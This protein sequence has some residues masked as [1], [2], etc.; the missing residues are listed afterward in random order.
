M[1]VGKHVGHQTRNAVDHH[2]GLAHPREV[3]RRTGYYRNYHA[4]QSN[5]TVYGGF[6]LG[7]G[8]S[9]VSS[10]SPLFDSNKASTGL[11][12]GLAI[13]APVSYRAPLFLES[14]PYYTEK[15]G[16]STYNNEKF[17]YSLNYLEVPLVLK[18]KYRADRDITIEPFV[19]GYLACGVGGKIKDYNHRAAYNS[20]DDDYDDTFN[21]F[22]G[23]L[24]LGVGASFQQL[25][26]E[27]GYDIGLANVG[28][29]NFDETRNGCF[30][31]TVGINF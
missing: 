5:S 31:L 18:Y 20:F 1:R 12:I 27:A 17:T 9:T 4:R 8:V 6:R 11:N 15:G 3:P 14:G 24:K 7:L 23:G 21:R 22:D 10:D 13:G 28:K 25:Y 26:L 2:V 30:N 29:D 16:K 19:G